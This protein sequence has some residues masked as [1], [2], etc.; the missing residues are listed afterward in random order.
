MTDTGNDATTDTEGMHT[1]ETT[2]AADVAEGNDQADADDTY[3]AG[4]ENKLK[5]ENK[6]LRQDRKRWEAVATA[7][8]QAQA[9][10]LVGRATRVREPALLLA[11]LKPLSEYV[12]GETNKL[13]ADE[14]VAD[15]NE[16]MQAV[17]PK[18]RPDP[19][20]GKGNGS[21]DDDSSFGGWM[22]RARSDTGTHWRSE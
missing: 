21:G 12:D 17:T 2:E 6:R 10:A 22:R 14:L 19:D 1:D 11:R 8:L 5:G 9:E 13:N 16:F 3:D 4:P 18:G 20:Q 7:A 15:A